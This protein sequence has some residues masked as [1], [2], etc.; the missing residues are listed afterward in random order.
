MTKY[1]LQ[2]LVAAIPVLIGIM[3]VTFALARLLPGD[4][5]VAMLGERANEETCTA[6]NARYG[7]DEPLITQFVIYFRDVM[8]GDLGVSFRYGKP[9]TQLIAERLPVTMELA[10][11]AMMI[12]IVVGMF[13]GTVSAQ[14]QNSS[15]D[16]VTMVGANLGVSIPVFVLGL[17]LAYVFAIILRD[18]PFALAPSG[19][20][21]AGMAVT[22]LPEKLGMET[23]DPFYRVVE[24]FS[25]LYIF[26]AI[27][28]LDGEL[29]WDSVKHLILPAIALGTI[30]LAII[31]RMTRSSL[32]EVIGQ[33][34][35]RTARAK[36]LSERVVL[37]RHALRNALL[38]VVTI[39]GLSFGFLLSGAVL[40]ETIFGFSGVGRI[41]FDSILA[42]DYAVI[43]GFTLVT[44]VGFLM[45]NLLVDILYGFLD[46]RI[47]LG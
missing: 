7:L 23:G 37:L 10:F 18:T 8:T 11:S 6:F 5:C 42:R 19:R 33:D 36:G 25:N 35:T 30:P 1:V 3:F 32:L 44:A 9:V 46:P 13:L 4:P 12:A 27:V 24:F 40:T 34:Y 31:A 45:I 39:I 2:R 14:R 41:L 22:F 15:V 28:N 43:Q 21:T 29:F 16:V 20:L 17:F 38:P 26:N 47:R